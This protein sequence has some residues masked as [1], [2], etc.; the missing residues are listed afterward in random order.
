MRLSRRASSA[1][2]ASRGCCSW[3]AVL[4][5]FAL[6]F[7]LEDQYLF[8]GVGKKK[9]NGG[10]I[11]LLQLLHLPLK[12]LNVVTAGL[13]MPLVSG[14]DLVGRPDERSGPGPGDVGVERARVTRDDTIDFRLYPTCQLNFV[15]GQE[16]TY[17]GEVLPRTRHRG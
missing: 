4:A 15:K 8:F 12:P 3:A 13:L 9:K 14:N 11:L 1:L 16:N 5:A 17:G 2:C 10:H 7:L 6:A